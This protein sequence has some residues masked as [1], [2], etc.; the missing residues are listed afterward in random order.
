MFL[1]LSLFFRVRQQTSGFSVGYVFFT[2]FPSSH[3]Q[4]HKDHVE[5]Y[6]ENKT[7]SRVFVAINIKRYD[8]GEHEK[9]VEGK[10]G[11][12]LKPI[13]ARVISGLFPDS[14]SK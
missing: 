6:Q 14:Y 4:L 3:H 5:V 12:A 1:L 8:V 2:V 7:A 9:S 10:R 13:K 11:E